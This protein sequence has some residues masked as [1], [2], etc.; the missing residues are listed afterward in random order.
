VFG[1]GWFLGIERM[2][3]KRFDKEH[4]A[5]FR[6]ICHDPQYLYLRFERDRDGSAVLAGVVE[7]KEDRERIA[8]LIEPVVGS[9]RKAKVVAKIMTCGPVYKMMQEVS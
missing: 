7:E 4:Q 6:R 8:N 9:C 3:T 2:K 5:I 1:T